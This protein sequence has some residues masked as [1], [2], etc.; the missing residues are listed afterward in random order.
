MNLVQVKQL[1]V[2]LLQQYQLLLPQNWS[3]NSIRS[4]SSSLEGCDSRK[5]IYNLIKIKSI[6]PPSNIKIICKEAQKFQNIR[7]QICNF[8]R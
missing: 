3:P 4:V 8:R 1:K 5:N 7:K 6:I 2:V